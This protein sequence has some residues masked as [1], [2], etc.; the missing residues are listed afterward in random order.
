MKKL[1]PVLLVLILP[2]IACILSGCSG[3]ESLHTLKISNPGELKEFF[4]WT[5]D[6]IPVV[7]AHRGG[8]RQNFPENCLETFQNTLGEVHALIETDPRYT[9]DSVIVLMH[10]ATLERTT[11]GKGRVIDYTLEELRKLRLKDPE[12]NLT[13]YRIPTLDETLEWARSK[14]V[15]VLDRKDIPIEE[16]VKKIMEHGA[17]AYA[18][19]IAYSFDEAKRCYSMNPDV[20]MEIM[21]PD[22]SQV[23]LFEKAGVPWEN[24]VGFVSHN[25]AADTSIFNII[26]KK[27]VKC[28]VGSSRNHDLTYKKGTVSSEEVSALYRKMITDGADIIEADLA[29]EAGLSLEALPGEHISS[30][31]FDSDRSGVQY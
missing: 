21:L 26:H 30:S 19:V 13:D 4:R 8:A 16:R 3:K 7:T 11:S 28:I 9:R 29:I 27:G 6:R 15:L 12:G 23:N 5:Q 22:T 14:T 25:L 17:E 31:G 24:V 1:P 20:M 2:A 10:D 18:M